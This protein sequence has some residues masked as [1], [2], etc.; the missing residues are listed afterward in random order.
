M[1]DPNLRHPV[2]PPLP[3]GVIPMTLANT[4][5]V[6]SKWGRNGSFRLPSPRK[7]CSGATSRSPDPAREFWRSVEFNMFSLQLDPSGGRPLCR[8]ARGRG[9]R[10]RSSTDTFALNTCTTSRTFGSVRKC[11]L[12][13]LRHFLL[14][15]FESQSSGSVDCRSY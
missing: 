11:S 12:F 13:L 7:A 14:I 5:K 1:H 9:S 6:R 8:V 4:K 15:T 10:R 3:Q 2:T